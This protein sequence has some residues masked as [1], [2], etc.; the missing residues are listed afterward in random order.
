MSIEQ[1]TQLKTQC[2]SLLEKHEEDIEDWY[3]EKQDQVKLISNLV[4]NN[5]YWIRLQVSFEEYVCRQKALKKGEDSCL[6]EQL[7][8]LKKKKKSKKEKGETGS[9]TEL[10]LAW[11][12]VPVLYSYFLHPNTTGPTWF[13]K[14]CE[15]Q[16][17][18]MAMGRGVRMDISILCCW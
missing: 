6:A 2:E 4:E 15:F 13:N 10:W 16:R 18:R 14:C 17:V 3:F 9:K 11:Y 5:L 1:V 12:F 7:Q 8:K